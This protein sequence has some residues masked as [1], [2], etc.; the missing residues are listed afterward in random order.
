MKAGTATRRGTLAASLALLAGRA[1]AQPL[2]PGLAALIDGGSVA[3]I[4]HTSAPGTGDPPGF[5]LGSCETQRNLDDAGRGEAA[6]LGRRLRE[7]GVLV[8][9]VRSSRWCRALETAALAFPD[10]P[11]IPDAALDDLADNAEAQAR[12]TR[13]ARG[14]AARWSGR[15]GVLALV[16]HRA[17]VEVM[18]GIAA[19]DGEIVVLRPQRDGFTIAGRWR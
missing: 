11:T 7:A 5:R 6:D 16:T 17:T 15:Q 8:T 10:V 1:S 2:P 18:T 14:L 3:C 4:C 12:Q 9:Q 19:E 13:R